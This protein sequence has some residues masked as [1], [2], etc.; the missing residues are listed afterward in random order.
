M[1]SL[2]EA[3]KKVA[4]GNRPIDGPATGSHF[5]PRVR[6]DL[7]EMKT[8]A[9]KPF[10]SGDP[11]VSVAHEVLGEVN[12][13]P[14]ISFEHVPEWAMGVA[15]SMFRRHDVEE[16]LS[17][18]AVTKKV[19][20]TG[21]NVVVPREEGESNKQW[22]ARTK[23]VAADLDG[24][25]L[26]IKNSSHTGGRIYCELHETGDPEIQAVLDDVR[27][28]LDN[29]CLRTDVLARFDEYIEKAGEH[30]GG[31]FGIAIVCPR[32][33]ADELAFSVR[34]ARNSILGIDDAPEPG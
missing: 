13:E 29:V 34:L 1:G 14:D 7:G 26:N 25:G 8:G 33:A 21:Y 6:A 22:A 20:G 24:F 16:I 32:D 28:A 4:S 31:S 17:D 11:T 5:E 9:Y 15:K 27:A 3:F 2:T 10:R 19:D 12:Q 23:G 30:L 18:S